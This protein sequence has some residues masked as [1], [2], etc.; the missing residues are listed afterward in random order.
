[1]KKSNKGGKK[2]AAI[3]GPNALG[4]KEGGS[5][6]KR[7]EKGKRDISHPPSVGGAV[8]KGN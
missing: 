3:Y 5:S 8:N 1:M 2:N 4:I 7:G 6:R